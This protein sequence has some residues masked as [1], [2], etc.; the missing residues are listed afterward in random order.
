MEQETKRLKILGRVY[1]ALSAILMIYS[2]WA[3][4]EIDKLSSL[5]K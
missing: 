5:I 2:I 1:M 3:T 4:I